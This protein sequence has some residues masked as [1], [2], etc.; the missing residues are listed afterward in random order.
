MKQHIETFFDQVRSGE[1]EIYN[2]FSLQHELGIFLRN[3]M[4][5]HKVQFERNVSFFEYQKSNLYKKEIDI[6][7]SGRENGRPM[8]AL[9]L[10]YPRNGQVPESMYSF[11]KDIA[12]LEQLVNIGFEVAYF[13]AVADDK[14][15][16]SGSSSGIYAMFRGDQSISGVINKP[17]GTKDTSVNIHGSYQASWVPVAGTTKYCLIQVGS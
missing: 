16:Y 7:I 5:N 14:L 6:T 12:F 4:P 10:K 3:L 2:E 11:C 1:I 13:I 8:C 17:T 9:E 15:F